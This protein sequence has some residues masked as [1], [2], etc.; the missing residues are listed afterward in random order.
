MDKH[1]KGRKTIDKMC[2]HVQSWMDKHGQHVQPWM[3][4]DEQAWQ[5]KEKHV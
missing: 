3:D 2:E 1:E 5:T 4:K